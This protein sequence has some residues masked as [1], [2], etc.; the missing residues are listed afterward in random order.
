MKVKSLV[1]QYVVHLPE[2]L[3]AGVLYISEEFSLAAHLCCCGCGEEVSLPLNPARWSILRS[4]TG[5]VSVCPSVGNWKYNCGS[6]YWI[7]ENQVIDAGPM[8]ARAIEQV[9]ERD[10]R[11]RNGYVAL[12]N[13]SEKLSWWQAAGRKANQAVFRFWQSLFK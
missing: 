8:S 7:R 9:I 6:H 12:K 2:Q 5:A 3:E 10:K 13:S 1:P 4:R 11:D